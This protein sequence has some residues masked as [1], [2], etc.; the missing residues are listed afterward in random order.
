MILTEMIHD[1]AH[2]PARRPPAAARRASGSG[3]ACSRG[4][5][6]GDTLVVETTNFNGKNR[7]PGRQREPEGHRA[8]HARRRR[9]DRLQVH[10]RGSGDVGEAVDGGDADG[11]DRRADLR[12]RLPR[13]E[14]RHREHPGRRARRGEASAEAAAE[15]RIELTCEPKL[16]RMTVGCRRRRCCWPPRRS[17]AHHA[18]A[19]EFDVEQAA[20]AEGHARSSGRWSTRTPGSTST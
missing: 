12:V 10:G 6:E 2:H 9:H 3:W 15:E 14:L 18:F 1:V 4:R 19:A 13:G 16:M 7:V 8:L 17:R 20:Q 11:E 5:W